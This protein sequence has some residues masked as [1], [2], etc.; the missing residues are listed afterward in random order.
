MKNLSTAHGRLLEELSRWNGADKQK[1]VGE[2][3]TI[4]SQKKELAILLGN[5]TQEL[6]GLEPSATATNS[7]VHD[8]GFDRI[9]LYNNPVNLIKLQLHIWYPLPRPAV[10]EPQLV[11]NHRWD[12]SSAIIAGD[13]TNIVFE[14]DDECPDKYFHYKYFARGTKEH[15]A[16]EF[17]GMRSLKVID[18]KQH[19]VGSVYSTESQ[20]L[21]KVDIPDDRLVSTMIITH[22]NK[23]WVDNDLFSEKRIDHKG[24]VRAWSPAL[25]P[26]KVLEK[27]NNLRSFIGI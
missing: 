26:K 3:L 23:V 13:Y 11:H 8:N 4:L 1:A 16:L 2:A 14:F 27:I 21:H 15:N 5:Y 9:L 25:E 17:V 6:L 24:N 20:A 22:E 10:R 12:F 7:Y 19:N 18:S